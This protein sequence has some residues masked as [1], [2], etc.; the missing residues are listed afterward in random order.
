MRVAT[1]LK[2]Q[3]SSNS[4][5]IQTVV[6]LPARFEPRIK[7]ELPYFR[8]RN[9]PRPYRRPQIAEIPHPKTLKHFEFAHC[10]YLLQRVASARV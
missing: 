2:H 1:L 6:E 8:H 4:L 9:R 5:F 10:S 3:S 7:E